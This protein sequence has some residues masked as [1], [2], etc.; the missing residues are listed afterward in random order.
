MTPAA[1]WPRASGWDSE[2]H[3]LVA[4][5]AMV[6]HFAFLAYLV[7]GG[8]LAWRWPSTIWLHVAVA[9]YGFLD[10]QAI[11]RVATTRRLAIGVATDQNPTYRFAAVTSSRAM[12]A[13]ALAPSASSSSARGRAGSS[14]AFG[15]TAPGRVTRLAAA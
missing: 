12:G 13:Q 14:P 8:F 3:R 1:L 10:V 15:V 7:V 11:P 6:A 9:L 4:D 2:G 5:A